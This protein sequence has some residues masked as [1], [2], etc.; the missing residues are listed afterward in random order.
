MKVTGDLT[1]H[2]FTM[3]LFFFFVISCNT[4]KENIYEQSDLEQISILG[5]NVEISNNTLA[6]HSMDELSKLVEVFKNHRTTT[7]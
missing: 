1:R 6:F 5:T 2:F 3:S 7:T 4:D